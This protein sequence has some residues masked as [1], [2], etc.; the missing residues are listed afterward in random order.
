M[1]SLN[2]FILAFES[3]ESKIKITDKWM[4]DNYIKF[5]ELYF[6]NELPKP[7]DVTLKVHDPGH[8]SWLGCQ[9]EGKPYFIAKDFQENGLYIMCSK[10]K[11][12]K[13]VKHGRTWS[14]E[15]IVDKETRIK[16][17]VE[18]QPY[19]YMSPK[20]MFTENEAED[21][22]IHEMVHLFTVKDGLA[23]LRAHGKEF[24]RKCKEIREIANSKHG[25]HYHLTT[26]A[27]DHEEY[28]LNDDEKKKYEA[29]ILRIAKQA[30]GAVMIY[31]TLD[32]HIKKNKVRNQTERFMFCSRNMVQSVIDEI[33]KVHQ[34]T[35]EYGKI[36]SMSV[37]D[38]IYVDFCNKYSKIKTVRKY[39]YWDVEKYPYIYDL[40]K[41]ADVQQVKIGESQYNS[42]VD[43]VEIDEKKSYTKPEIKVIPVE[44]PANTNMSDIDL[45]D[46]IDKVND[47]EDIK[48]SEETEKDAIEM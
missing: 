35:D 25:K 10:Q 37:V 38:G 18:L 47:E 8:A 6:N 4:H 16:S 42:L 41:K 44:I 9:G 22:L 23:P 1:K 43:M 29:E 19:I 21:T 12:Y 15:P 31:F 30:G 7:G 13:S 34:K 2:R 5:N 32:D 33:K 48:G 40:M 46:I 28:E 27:S 14:W 20:Y 17:I 26:F 39:I 11:G 3:S 36:L 45:V 24:A